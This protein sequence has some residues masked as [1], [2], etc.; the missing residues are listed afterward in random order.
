MASW[1]ALAQISFATVHGL[2]SRVCLNPKLLDPLQG[3]LKR[4]V[5][6]RGQTQRDNNDTAAGS[7][8]TVHQ[9]RART[10][11]FGNGTEG[12]IES[13]RRNCSIIHHG[14]VNI[15]NSVHWF[16]WIVFHVNHR[17]DVQRILGLEQL[18]V[19]PVAKEQLFIYLCDHRCEP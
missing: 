2:G 6:G 9:Y 4:N 3:S 17:F 13:F 16:V 18:S 14:D 10:Q 1:L 8:G 19:K 5:F 7:H 15:V 11:V 12:N